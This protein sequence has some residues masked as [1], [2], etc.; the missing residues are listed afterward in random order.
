ME[1]RLAQ[2]DDLRELWTLCEMFLESQKEY[3][4]PDQRKI[5]ALAVK[6]GIQHGEA[7]VVAKD[8]VGLIGFCAWT[9]FPDCAEGEVVAL[10][11]Y[12]V[13]TARHRGVSNEMRELALRHCREKGYKFVS[14]SV[15]SGNT[16]GVQSVTSSGGHIVGF[17][18]EY[19]L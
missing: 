7:I 17:L 4:A 15:R 3:G 1:V 18:V 5:L 10:G 9:G 12:V 6:W 19:P 13:P 11:T 2:P 16:A 14:G 8:E